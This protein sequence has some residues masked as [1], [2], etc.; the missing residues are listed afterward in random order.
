EALW[1]D[2]RAAALEARL[3]LLRARLVA[4]PA[5]RPFR[6]APFTATPAA[7][8]HARAVQACRERIAAG[9]LFQANL[10]L[11]LRSTLEGDLADL[12]VAGATAL[13][14]DRAAWVG[15]VASLS[16]ELY[17]ERRGDRVRSAPIKG[18]APRSEDPAALAASEK[19]RAENVMIVD[20]VRND[21]GRVCAHGSVE[22][23]A[24]A[25]PRPHA[26]VWHL[27][28]EVAGTLA[29][30]VGDGALVAATFPPGSVTGAP[31][32]AAM[33]VIG[34]LESAERQVFTGAI[35][36]AS[37]C[38]GLELSVAI[39][40]FEAGG[41]RLWLDVG[42]GVT[43]G[44][45]PDG[46]AA[47]ALAKAAPLLAA[48]GGALEEGDGAGASRAAGDAVPR[49]LRLGPRPT[50]RP[51]PAR[52]VFE[53]VLVRDGAP[54]DLDAH[55]ARLTASV[56]A[57]YGVTPE[58]PALPPLP[59]AARLRLLAEPGG[60][61]A[62]EVA[63]LPPA[64]DPTTLH[65]VVVPGGLGAHK[66]RDRRLL[67]ALAAH[68]APATP[69]L[70]DLD[71]WVLEASWA[72]VVAIGDGGALATPPLDGRILPGVGRAR[73]LAAHDV[74]ERPVHVTE[75]RDAWLT[76]ALRTVRAR[77]SSQPY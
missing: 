48:V 14:P 28:S 5:A 74:A 61:I 37:P 18:T 47:E 72:N 6:T 50:P 64:S 75:L 56:R 68:T 13:R 19:D 65:P 59:E 24:L 39:R 44:S 55:V 20:L 41:A 69:L 35:G 16:P 8:G 9:D 49:P 26:G 10:A 32:V 63:A 3:E 34:E 76:S 51:D 60:A 73:F 42:G 23:T 7:A 25:E 30:G 4:P 38:A 40:T 52:G 77:L 62:A 27:V 29:P 17:L 21:L 70:V 2:E 43:A 66:W 22:V 11:R 36:F 67:D 53:T 15:G 45:D 54:V 46:E 57:L 1:T 31:K 33:D 71:G 58:L 12:H